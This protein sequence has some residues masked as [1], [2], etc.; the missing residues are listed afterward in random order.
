MVLT[1]GDVIGFVGNTG[2]SDG[3]HIHYEIR[4]DGKP[5]DTYPFFTLGD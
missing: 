4:R 1:K 2:K 3:D 5:L